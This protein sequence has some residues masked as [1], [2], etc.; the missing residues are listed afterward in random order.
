MRWVTYL[1]L[2]AAVIMSSGCG[3]RFQN[4]CKVDRFFCF[5]VSQW[6]ENA[7]ALTTRRVF[8]LYV[9]D[10]RISMPAHSLFANI[11]GKR[12]E[13][14]LFILEQHLER[15]QTDREIGFYRPI[16]IHVIE[17]GFDFCGSIHYRRILTLLGAVPGG[18]QRRSEKQED[19]VRLCS[20]PLGIVPNHN[21]GR[22]RDPMLNS[23]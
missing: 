2:L 12:G 23:D 18:G 4:M 7:A 6:E 11:L 20:S 16:L 22:S 10:R 15:N 13:E 8:E 9:L 3:Q 21:S 14:T 1:T 19:L 5:D 17:E